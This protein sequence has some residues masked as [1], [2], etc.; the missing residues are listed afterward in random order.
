MPQPAKTVHARSLDR[1][2]ILI[3]D[4]GAARIMTVSPDHTH[5][6]RREEMTSPDIHRKTHD[7]VS[8]R[9][10]LGFASAG[11]RQHG[12]EA[13]TDA[14]ELAK[15]QFIKTVAETLNRH[16]E[17]GDFD[18]LVLTVTRAQLR[19]LQDAL[20][21]ATRSR[22]AAVIGKDLVKTPDHEIW[23]HLASEGAMPER[24]RRPGR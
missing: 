24:P 19:T 8:E 3:A 18:V 4:G 15:E 2:W 13:P 17:A 20:S 22:V 6:V 10:G 5:L 21:P 23:D 7:I 14:H 11:G 9:G 12:M 1:T 16:A